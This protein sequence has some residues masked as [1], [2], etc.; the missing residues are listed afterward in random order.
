[1]NM[2]MNASENE[3]RENETRENETPWS[4]SSLVCL[5][6]L[7]SRCRF[8]Q[9]RRAGTGTGNGNGNG[10]GNENENGNEIHTAGSHHVTLRRQIER[11][12]SLSLSLGE[13]LHV[14]NQDQVPGEREGQGEGQG[15]GER[16]GNVQY[17]GKGKLGANKL[18][19][20]LPQDE[21]ATRGRGGGGGRREQ[22][23][24]EQQQ[25]GQGVMK[26]G[27]TSSGGGGRTWRDVKAELYCVYASC[28]LEEEI[29]K[30]ESQSQ[31]EME[32]KR[33]IHHG[34]GGTGGAREA[35]VW[36]DRAVELTGGTN[37]LV[38][39]EY[40][41]ALRIERSTVNKAVECHWRAVRL[42]PQEKQH[43]T[44]LACSL[45]DLGT[46][47]KN[48]KNTNDMREDFIRVSLDV[49][50]EYL[51]GGGGGGLG[52][53][54][55]RSDYHGGEN[56][57]KDQQRDERGRREALL[58]N[59][60]SDSSLPLYERV[61]KAALAV[62]CE[63]TP[64]WYNMGVAYGERGDLDGAT[65]A[66]R[67]AIEL[68]PNYTE[69]LCNYGALLRS[70]GK[71]KEAVETFEKSLRTSPNHAMIKANL[72]ATLCELGAQIKQKNEGSGPLEESGC[73]LSNLREAIVRYEQALALEPKHPLVLY[74]LGVAYA[75]SGDKHK[76]M[77]MYELTIHFAPQYAEAWNNLG[78]ILRD[79]GNVERAIE[80]YKVAAGAN[81][82]FGQPLNNL[83]IIY[84]G[85]GAVTKSLQAFQAAITASPSYAEV[86]NNLGVLYRDIGE[87]HDCLNAY[88]KCLELDPKNRSA[89]HNLL[90]GL[91][92]IHR[93][94]EEIVCKAHE[95]W[96]RNFS[97]Q[98]KNLLPRFKTV[99]SLEGK[100]DVSKPCSRGQRREARGQG[101]GCFGV[102]FG[103]E[104]N[105]F[106]FRNGGKEILLTEED[107]L[108]EADEEKELTIGYVSPDL[109]THSVSY[110]AEAPI[111]H[112]KNVKVIVYNVTPTPDAKTDRLKTSSGENVLWRDVV[113]LSELNLARLIRKDKVDVLVELTGHTANNRLAAVA[114]R[115]APIQATWIGYPNSTGLKEV[116]YRITD[117]V[118]DPEDTC[119][120]YV[121]TLER[122]PG[123]FLCYTP[124]GDAPEVQPSPVIHT[125][126]FTF[127]TFN[128]LAKITNEVVELWSLI[129]KDSK[130]ECRLLVKAKGMDDETGRNRVMSLFESHGIADRVDLVPLIKDNRGHLSLY[131]QVDVALDPFPYAG[132]TTTCEALWMGVPTITL[133]GSN[134]AQNVG[135][136]INHA[137]GL[138]QFVAQDKE[139]Y[140]RIAQ[141]WSRQSEWFK[142]QGLRENLRMQVRSSIL[143]QAE[144]FVTNLEKVYRKWWRTYCAN[145]NA[146]ETP[147]G[148]DTS[149]EDSSQF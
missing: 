128:A 65:L 133:R 145:A 41:K 137:V 135:A 34:G 24:D 5:E 100:R 121:E 99:R 69:A 93:G 110:F 42:E 29:Q 113:H 111:T 104:T 134:H 81:P 77:A 70:Q 122:L 92:Y 126:I 25:Q 147:Q 139:H 14:I 2:N 22:G 72:A 149:S 36:Y 15:E 64:S 8:T 44:E 114:M 1:M 89:G 33:G 136:S 78:V 118:T 16:K 3:T 112:H 12:L 18:V 67:K 30:L 66:Y 32:E 54:G 102:D 129:L 71:M 43:R 31:Q 90:M 37:A 83:G 127:G 103:P 107:S 61:Y 6:R 132:T 53:S 84:A 98:Y 63:Y 46:Y 123:C 39:V 91:N 62:D 74:N 50:D 20:E 56:Q 101:Q 23:C 86:Y 7:L 140:L 4:S 10:N 28:L 9:Q 38:W 94:E 120:R 79:L 82:Q 80:C 45:N 19:C 75:E 148:E 48:L 88:K 76:A 106:D 51:V 68:S 85:R 59:S 17:K 109:F 108:V 97:K 26:T 60:S 73:Y 124:A 47:L 146:N 117:F 144:P 131:G 13:P 95:D 141:Y 52:K 40:G 105:D 87:M 21:S 11:A 138:D 119:Q 55:D 58:L 116:D 125:G 27:S 115:P 130:T 49:I 57:E 142:L 96:G 143:C 35:F